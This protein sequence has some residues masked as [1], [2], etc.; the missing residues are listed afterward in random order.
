[1][2]HLA[3]HCNK[4]HDT[5]VWPGTASLSCRWKSDCTASRNSRRRIRWSL[6]NSPNRDQS[7]VSRRCYGNVL[8]WWHHHGRLVQR[9]IWCINKLQRCQW[10]LQCILLSELDANSKHGKHFSRKFRKHPQSETSCTLTA[11]KWR[12]PWNKR[13]S[14]TI[15]FLGPM[16]FSDSTLHKYSIHVK[17]IPVLEIWLIQ[18]VIALGLEGVTPKIFFTRSAKMQV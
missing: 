12:V 5:P 4:G 15:L 11:S 3:V 6:Q 10:K 8:P 17:W 14:A 2:S 7:T 16:W 18:H 13:L 1:M 9:T